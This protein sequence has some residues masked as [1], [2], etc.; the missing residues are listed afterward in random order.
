MA[1][2]PARSLDP[3][4]K[5]FP[6]DPLQKIIRRLSAAEK[7]LAAACEMRTWDAASCARFVEALN[8]WRKIVGLPRVGDL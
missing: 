5:P 6:V 4:S 3:L 8:D 2:A 1:A 7:A